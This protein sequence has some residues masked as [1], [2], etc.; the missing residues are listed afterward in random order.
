MT[1]LLMPKYSG[2]MKTRTIDEIEAFVRMVA[3]AGFDPVS[4]GAIVEQESNR[5]WSPSVRGAKA[6]SMAPGYAIGLIQFSPD[7]AKA[8]KSSTEQMAK[9]SFLEQATYVPKYYRQFFGGPGRFTRPGDYY[10]AGWG[11]GVGA[12]DSY[13]LAKKGSAAYTA[14]SALDTN[15]DGE[16]T[17]GDLSA[18]LARIVAGGSLNGFLS[19]DLSEVTLGAIRARFATAGTQ[20]QAELF[21]LLKWSKL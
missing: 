19:F 8:L 1:I 3:D 10:A 7:T 17:V 9:M 12:V 5:T 18:S 6:F 15:N 13:V 2:M 20:Q 11:S 16:I 14:N 4:V 21:G